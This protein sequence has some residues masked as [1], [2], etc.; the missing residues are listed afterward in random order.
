M[1]FLKRIFTSSNSA[2]NPASQPAPSSVPASTLNTKSPMSQENSSRR[3]LLRLVLRDTLNRAGIP[4]SW[5][6]VDLLA[7]TSRGRDP[8]I[9]VRLLL[10]HWDPRLM[11]HGI[12]FENAYR[13]R[14]LTLDPLAERWLLGIS[15]QY[16]LEDDSACPPMPH[17]GIW[18][19]AFGEEDTDV[20]ELAVQSALRHRDPA[21]LL[22]G[23]IVISGPAAT[24]DPSAARPAAAAAIRQAARKAV[25]EA[26]EDSRREAKADLERLF[27]VRDA[28][29]Q[30]HAAT[31]SSPQFAATEPAGLLAL[32]AAPD[33]APRNGHDAAAHASFAKTDVFRRS[34]MR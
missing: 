1:S 13:K 30:R 17:P 29:L 9:H 14:V 16:S 27:A 21:D 22:G 20:A 3:E 31:Q 2:G 12:A 15:W 26:F 8:G 25:P 34:D 32:P 18:T 7:A 6:G 5:V 33:A 24:P 28:D 4:G 23:S 11:L 10:K 19:S